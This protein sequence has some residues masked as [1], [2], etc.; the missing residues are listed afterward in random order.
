MLFFS[1]SGSGP[2][3]AISR[4]SVN[5]GKIQKAVGDLGSAEGFHFS[6]SDSALV[7]GV[8]TAKG[9]DAGK[10]VEALAAALRSASVTEAELAGAKKKLIGQTMK[11]V[12]CSLSFAQSLA[13]N[14]LGKGGELTA[15]GDGCVAQINAVSLGEVQV[16]PILKFFIASIKIVFFTIC[17]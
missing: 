11:Q 2:L 6:Y 8:V 3:T 13:L 7:G 4:V 14:A 12:G 5:G 1:V 10:A 16:S 15:A 9:K 17:H